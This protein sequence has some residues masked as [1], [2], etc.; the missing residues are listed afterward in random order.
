MRK[1]FMQRFA[2]LAV[3]FACGAASAD[4]LDNVVIDE[5]GEGTWVDTENVKHSFT[6]T[7]MADPSG[8][9]ASALVYTTPF[10][11]TVQGDYAIYTPGP[12]GG[13]LVGVVRFYGNNTMIFYDS[14][15]GYDPSVADGSGM[16]GNV[17]IPFQE[18]EGGQ[19]GATVVTPI[20]G[21][22]G[23]DGG[24]RQYTFLSVYPVPEP[25]SLALL[26]CSVALL[27]IRRR[28]PIG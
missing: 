19:V 5:Y 9:T 12:E 24:N 14:D 6:G 20:A 28:R 25:G 15:S 27:A 7:F 17:T 23:F 11:F 22:A 13:E 21:M 4:A 16:P 1:Q 2:L 26:A 18:L 10:T 3:V 8:G